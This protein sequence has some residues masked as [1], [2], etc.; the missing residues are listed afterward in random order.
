M[1][2]LF[3]KFQRLDELIVWAGYAGLAL[4]VFCETGLLAGFFLPGDSL[5]VTAG[6]AASQGALNFLLLNALLT[7]AAVLGD[8]TGYFLGAF[9]G[10][11]IFK[12]EKSFF[13]K[14]AYLEKTHAFFEKYGGKTIVLARFVPIVRS[15]APT[16]A[17]AGRMSYKK[18]LFYNVIGGVGWVF[19]MTSVGYFLGRV[20][21]NIEKRLPLVAGA[22][23]IISFLPLVK[24]WL[25]SRSEK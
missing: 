25:A 24:E 22:V 6:L 23:I 4:I 15:F 3:S 10:P 5:L 14:K 11:K 17:G 20:V 18:F 19:S 16:V 13:F 7:A 2:E 9:A 8:T 12:K 1:A 21:P